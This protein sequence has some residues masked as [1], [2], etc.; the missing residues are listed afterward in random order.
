MKKTV[1]ILLMLLA[2][3][4]IAAQPSQVK[5]A[6]QSVFSLTSFNEKGEIVASTQG[7]FID[8]Q[9]TGICPFKPFIGAERATVV[10]A[11]GNPAEVDALLGVDELY[12]V[13]KFRVKASTKAI[14]SATAAEK[15]RAKAWLMPYSIKSPEARQVTISSVERFHENYNYYILEGEVPDNA[16]GCPLINGNGQIL[17][18]MHKSDTHI[19]AVDVNY[20]K[21]LTVNGL[22][23]LDASLQET[24]IRTALPDQEEEAITMMTLKKGSVK[25]ETYKAYIN[26]FLEKFPT[27]AFGYH[28][29]GLTQIAQD[30]FDEADKTMRTAV[31]ESRAK[32]EA[33]SDY[34]NLIYQKMVYKADKPYE[35]W[36]L[37]KA[38]EEAKAA[39]GINPQPI[40]RHQEAQ[41][42]YA[43]GKYQEA[44]DIFMELTKSPISNAELYYE[45]AQS[46]MQLKAPD[47][48]IR[49]LLD[50]AVNVG[51]RMGTGAAPYVLAR[52]RYL[53]DKGEFRAALKDYNDYD[54]LTATTDP[55]FFYMRYKC[56]IEVRQWQQALFDIARASL[57]NPKEPTYFA[58]WAS[59]DLRVKRYDEAISA[60]TKCIE[61]APEYADG[62]LLLGL[63]QIE[64]GMKEEGLKN[65]EKA[66]EL[67]DTRADQYIEK[68]K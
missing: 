38:L 4:S 46:K 28:E 5:K 64:K 20:I 30:L 18:I 22:S 15:Q 40:Y 57:L 6:A 10:D 65:L 51:K 56:E 67:G 17:G 8:E 7:V 34:A 53:H 39:Y 31:K 36:T 1:H 54:T 9:G 2:S 48:E 19:T 13:A 12:D 68:N 62:Y 42:I 35:P 14:P 32:D 21:Q 26:E 27:A 58:E 59:L 11:D 25:D 33:H 45:A 63:A 37:D 47:T 55:V 52:A 43:Q 50:S 49:S 16:V 60:A 24:G 29:L 61:L 41:I 66:K 3:I 23:S 44:Y